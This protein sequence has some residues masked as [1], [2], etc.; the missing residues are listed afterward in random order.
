[1]ASQHGKLRHGSCRHCFLHGDI[2]ESCL[3]EKCRAEGVDYGPDLSW[4]AIILIL[5]GLAV[6][7]AGYPVGNGY[8]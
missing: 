5:V 1:M 7:L 6:A 8:R 2:D 4:V 3:C